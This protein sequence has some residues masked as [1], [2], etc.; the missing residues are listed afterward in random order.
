MSD[1]SMTN[2]NTG[3]EASERTLNFIE[4]IV[5]NDNA[6]RV[7]GLNERGVPKVHTRFPPEPNGYLHVGHAKS[8]CLN[9]GLALRYQGKFNMR[10]DD[11]NPSK[12]E[13]EYVDSIIRDVKWIT[14][15]FDDAGAGFSAGSYDT[16]PAAG[17]LFYASNYF[18]QMYLFAEELIRKGK[19][20]VCD[21]TGDEVSAR[22]GKPGVP[23]TSPHRDRPI[24]ESL[25]L[26][27]DMRMGKFP[28]GARTL[29]AKIDLA[30]P[31]FNLRDPVM[32]RIVHESHHNTGDAWCIY[33]MYDWAHGIEDSLE[34]IT[35]SICTLEFED[36]RPLYDWF[37]DAIN[38]GRTDDGSGPWGRRIQHPQQIEFA[39]FRP[40]YTILS[41]RNLLKMV[42]ERIVSGWDD[43]RMP[44]ISG[45]RRRGYT[46]RA[47]RACM[48]DVGITKVESSIDI[49]RMENALRDHLNRVAPRAMGVL[50]P[51][52][53][54]ITNWPQGNVD[55]L[56]FVINPEDP[57]QPKRKTRFAR[58][59]YIERDDFME[60]AEKGFF[61]LAVGQEVRLRWAYFITATGVVKDASGTITEVHA[62]YDPATRGG[63]APAG[64]DGQPLRKVKGTIHWV[65]AD[66]A[67]DAEV[68]LFDRLFVAEE[69][70]TRTGNWADDLHP[71]S[72][73][74]ARAKLEQ[75]LSTAKVGD[76]FQF[77]R[78]GYF[79]VDEDS[80]SG[81]LVLN[82]AV[83]L[84]D[85]R[86]AGESGKSKGAGA[87][88]RMYS[89]AE[90]AH[91]LKLKQEKLAAML[92]GAGI[93]DF[94]S[95][96]PA[97]LTLAEV[98]GL[99]DWIK[100]NPPTK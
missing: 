9:F 78:L 48:E 84:K 81:T 70:G 63:D 10:F 80:V 53:V 85:S 82:R 11:T 31:N 86:P 35:H 44:T 65:S 25:A 99:K 2:T 77:E 60:A 100:K 46:P 75:S 93:S 91:E 49:G 51:L 57:A 72:L 95:R 68:R 7:W 59:I 58:E 88:G 47:I 79:R 28:N 13:Q 61:R 66:H 76:T 38:E 30:S 24:E 18:E 87:A 67:T 33:P 41:K 39:K 64:P 32:Y 69:P 23:A 37:I 6:Q 15:A 20:Y 74:V 96:T 73:E 5:E 40:T 71:R 98:R 45:L 43:P 16:G 17:G 12:E 22:R 14:S 26:F 8:I 94:A 54:V 42:S 56:D 29:R 34:G 1:S 3:G 19:A 62:T 92:P 97:Q 55:D 52:K 36:H 90:A 89:I 83:T 27:R 4:Q 21:L 50:R